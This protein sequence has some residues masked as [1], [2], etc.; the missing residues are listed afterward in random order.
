MFKR[1]SLVT[2]QAG[3]VLSP[4]L[5]H[6]SYGPRAWVQGSI[7]IYGVRLGSKFLYSSDIS[8]DVP[9]L[10]VDEAINSPQI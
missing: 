7:L 9:V 6:D 8:P 3:Y 2:G 4:P 5:L 10:F 1:T